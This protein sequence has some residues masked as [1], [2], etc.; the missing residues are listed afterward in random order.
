MDAIVRTERAP[1]P[2]RLRSDWGRRL[3]NELFALFVALLLL[4]VAGLVL[5]DT[6]PGHRFIIDR[7][8]RIE[9]ASGLRITIGR[10]D[11]SIFGK[12]QLRSVAIADSRGVFLRSPNIQ[13]DWSPGAWLYNELYIDELTAD[14]VAL[15]RLPTLKKTGRRGPILPGFDIHIGEI[16]V[17]RLDIGAAVGGQPRSGRLS[18]KATVRSGRALVELAAILNNGGDRIAV[19]LDAEPDRDRL[20]VGAR[21]VSPANGLVPALV[22]TRRAIDLTIDGDGSWQRW[23]GEAALNLAGRP[24][25]RLALAA[26]NG[27]YRLGGRVAA[28]Q[29]L[30]GKL[31]RLTA[32]T[33]NVRAN[34]TFAANL[35]EGQITAA[36]PAMRAV[37]RGAVDLAENRYERVRVGIDLLRPPALFTNMTGKAVRM[38]WTLDGAFD[39]ADYSYRLT[40]QGVTFDNTGFVGLRAEGRGRLAPWPMRVPIRLSARAITGI[41]DVAGAM[42]ANPRIEGWLS[43]TPKLV[44]G[45]GLR[46]TSAKWSGKL[47]VLIDLVT[48]RFQLLVSG[49]LQ[50]YQ[51]PGLGIVDV[52]T[53][54]KVVPGPGGKGSLVVGTAKAWVRR[55]DNSFFRDLTGGLP[56]LETNLMRGPDGVVR[57]TDLQIYSPKLRLSGSGQRARDG[58]FHIV[59]SGR[60]ARYGPLK[61]SLDGRIERP[62]LDIL[63]DRPNEALG[64]RAVHL[65]LQ[66]TAAGFDYRAAGGS[67]L[68]PFTSNGRILLPRNGRTII[69]IA[70]LNT[71]G[72][73]ASGDLRS[74]TGG[75]SGR[76]VLADGT[77]G[78][79]LDF[80]PAEG[81]QRI[82]AHLTANGARFPGAFAV[83]SGRADGTVILADE[84]TTVDGSIDARGLEAGGVSL[85][86]LTANAKLV[87]GSGQVRAAFAGRRG[88]AF[89]FS[90]LADVSPDTIRVTGSGRIERQPLVLN[91][92][93]VLT[94]SGDGWALAP[95]RFAFAGSTATLAG[96]T[97]SRP[98]VQAQVQGMP[99]E[100]L[101]V[102]W[103]SL[104]F[105]GSATGRVDYAWAGNRTGRL[106]LK[107][108]GFS[109]AGLVLASKPIDVAIAASVSGNQAAMRAVAAS[110]GAT[111]GRAQARF[112]PMGGGPLVAE[113]LNAPLFAQLRYS[114]PADTLWRLT[115]SEVLDLSGPLAVGADIGGRLAD[116]QIRGSLRTKNARAESA[117]TGMVIDQLSSQARF[118]GPQLIFSQISGRTS[119]GGSV[120]GRGS[121]T[122]SGGRTALDLGFAANQALLL[123]RDDVAARVTGPLQIRSDGETGTISG[124]LR[125]NRGRF[126]LGRAS[127]AAAVPRLA[128]R[129]RLVDTEEV[130][131]RAKVHAW[132]LAM[133]VAGSDLRVEGLGISSRWT[134][135]LDIGGF[136]DAP[137]FTGRADLVRGEYDF[138]GRNF[139]LDRGIIRFR[140][141]DS[142]DPLLDIRAEAQVQGLD[143]SVLVRG[144]GLK[145]EITFASTP[146]LPQDELLSR[147]L[148]GTSITNLSAPEALQLASAVAAMRSGSGSLDPINALRRAVGLDRLRI[149]PADIATGQRTAVAAGKY[150][151]RKLFVEVVTDG[152][153][154]SA[155]RAEYQMTRWLS[156]LSTVSTIG[157][158]SAAVRVSKDY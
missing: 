105:K 141:E 134:T 128:V 98:E 121:V 142:P 75:F 138:A 54:L 104:D 123:N 60:Q 79:T 71:G 18:G 68:G 96:R 92:A 81:A 76:L 78:G 61:L 119:G 88:A 130:I 149:V 102:F 137:R 43:L 48:G 7:M 40:S 37:A 124:N 34:G 59:A 66:P 152:Q 135:D 63:L 42:L 32:P 131:E 114:G 35:L 16:E 38:V 62:R 110:N 145:P 26:D 90:T 157:R 83:R 73:R 14:R 111:V 4:L 122:F 94:R 19:R 6:A 20:D 147:I 93:A 13:L 8:S 70:A 97:G 113:L 57:F 95:T 87:N 77:L 85:A 51:I 44:R 143:A 49:G 45:E 30:S 3:L 155:T 148:F 53:D 39:R 12:S 115:G 64:L 74:D 129:E 144:T 33:V 103:P 10:I 25:A 22:G 118:S 156:L 109:R 21:I 50:R 139:R 117:V 120:T 5:L 11:G 84:R 27:R 136:A 99:L 58:T 47:S 132:K 154:Y 36:S 23:R 69:S 151:T 126:Q 108:R 158:S 56:R 133:K 31:Q 17:R 55:L 140:S 15:A 125:L 106:D 41:G 116:P 100:V 89:A 150:I 24:T 46:L 1:A 80:A 91:Q 29:V 2:R 86:R 112:A 9:T 72:A 67:K 101:D 107:V 52:I 65:L 82:E 28:A 127:D 146:Q 153:G